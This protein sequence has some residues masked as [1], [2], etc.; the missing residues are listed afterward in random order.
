MPEFTAPRPA[1]MPE[2][3]MTREYLQCMKCNKEVPSTS[4]V[5]DKCPHCGITWDA[6]QGQDGVYR[7][8]AGKPVRFRK[9]GSIVGVVVFV[10]AF[11]FKLVKKE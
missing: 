11:L 2:M 4:K 10:L 8:A 5:G 6:E 7:D 9:Y 3:E 1:Q